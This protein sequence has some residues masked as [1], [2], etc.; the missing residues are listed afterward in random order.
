MT[1]FRGFCIALFAWV[2][3][4][5]AVCAFDIQEVTSPRGIKAWLVEAHTVPIV[6]LNFSFDGGAALDPPGKEGAADLLS[7]MLVEGAG[8]LSGEKFKSET[9]RLAVAMSFSATA[10]FADGSFACLSKNRDDSFGLLR[11]AVNRPR[12]DA[13]AFA[14]VQQLSLQ[15]RQQ[16]ALDQD[17]ISYRAWFARAFPG[18]V[19]G[20]PTA[21]SAASVMAVTPD[22]LHKLHTVVFNR[23]TL[24][25]AVVGDIDAATLAQKLDEVFG[26]LPDAVPP[27]LEK[28][29]TMA[30][31]PSLQVITYDGPQT[32]I[33]FGNPGVLGEGRDAWA[34]YLMAEIMGGGATSARL[35]QSLRE[36]SGLTYGVSMLDSNAPHTSFQFGSMTTA[37]ATAKQALDLLKSELA[38][39]AKDG[40]SEDEVRRVK[41]Y[42]NGSY[43]L[44]FTTNESIAAVLLG[45]QQMGRPIDFMAARPGKVNSVTADDIKAVAARLLKPENQIFVLVGQPDL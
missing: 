25:V 35:N 7:S 5:Q 16:E 30:Q 31:A 33:S 2:A 1:R 6:S 26:S 15:S 18:Q 12:F 28:E 41:S 45:A 23:R 11:E 8:D 13:A 3:A 4:A 29:V 17:T 37:N 34:A 40:P 39:M 36:K 10:D 27:R 43:P 21:G 20:R 14:R 9:T 32:S 24:K 38:R 42:V 44:R 22:D 19:Y